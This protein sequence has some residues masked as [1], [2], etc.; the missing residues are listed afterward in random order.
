[1]TTH[2]E[3]SQNGVKA[4]LGLLFANYDTPFGAGGASGKALVQGYV[5]AVEGKPLDLVERTVRDFVTGKV[6]RATSKRG[7]LPTSEEFAARMAYHTSSTANRSTVAEGIHAPPY[8]PAWGAKLYALLLAGP[9]TTIKPTQFI[10]SMIAKGGEE[11]ERYRLHHQAA[12]GFRSVNVMMQAAGDARGCAVPPQMHALVTA[13]E[14]VPVGTA[15]FAEWQQEHEARGWPWFGE[16]GKQR[17]V[18]FPKGGPV[19]L[20]EFQK[21]LSNG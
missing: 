7:K 4:A 2:Q 20:Q 11:G 12:S 16:T 13:M 18:Y 1:M 3:T 17:V 6:E 5:W 14:A 21:V 10:A 9:D 19:A 15:M 8:G